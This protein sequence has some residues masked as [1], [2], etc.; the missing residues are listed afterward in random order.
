MDPALLDTLI[1][2]APQYALVAYLILLVHRLQSH[3]TTDRGDYR[4][5]LDA[6]DERH[7]AELTR[8][9]E[10]HAAELQALRAEM[11]DMRARVDDL[12]EQ[13]DRERRARW[14]AED[15]AA[16]ARRIACGDEPTPS[17]EG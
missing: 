9:R 10:A 11:A 14:R 4:A 1:Q 3:A 12:V 13:V 15:I 7:A 5:D 8:V 16:E 6:A 17:K 2:S